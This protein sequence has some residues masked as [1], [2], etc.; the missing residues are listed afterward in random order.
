M[1][2]RREPSFVPQGKIPEGKK[3]DT[4]RH[5]LAHLMA[6]AVQELFLGQVKFGIGPVI[7]N[8]FYY[9]FAL[10]SE[11]FLSADLS[12]ESLL[13]VEALAKAEAKEGLSVKDLPRIEEKMRKLISQNIAFKKKLISKAEAKKIFKWMSGNIQAQE[14]FFP[15]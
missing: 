11:A 7:E 5:S 13:K 2:K 6:Y 1:R 8:G 12:A 4:I 3:I 15:I 10:P 14:F 9:D